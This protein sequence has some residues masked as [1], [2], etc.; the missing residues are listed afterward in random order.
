MRMEFKLPYPIASRC[1]TGI[2]L[3]NYWPHFHGSNC[4]QCQKILKMRPYWT[5]EL[6]W[7]S[8]EMGRFH[9]MNLLKMQ[10][11]SCRAYMWRFLERRIT[12]KYISEL[13]SLNYSIERTKSN[14]F[15]QI[16]ILIFSTISGWLL[17]DVED[18]V[19]IFWHLS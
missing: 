14:L 1:T 16:R 10:G 19:K 15:F 8:R 12:G 3:Q 6:S 5:R 13:F 4:S 18:V 11:Y 9:A 2:S 17:G 7:L